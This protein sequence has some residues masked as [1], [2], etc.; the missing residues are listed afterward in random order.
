[1]TESRKKF[2]WRALPR[3]VK[4]Q[5]WVWLLLP[6]VILLTLL[7]NFFPETV[8]QVYAG[9]IR[10]AVMEPL[11][12]TVGKLPFSL[13]E[14]LILTA[15]IL[16]LVGLVYA[17]VQIVRTARR[18]EPVL[19]LTIDYLS[20]FTAVLLVGSFLFQLLYGLCYY[21]K[22]TTEAV[23][24]HRIH[25]TPQDMA[26][27]ISYLVD[28]LNMLREEMG[29]GENEK[30]VISMTAEEL[31]SAVRQAYKDLS[32]EHPIYAGD[33][34]D[35]K[36]VALSKPWTFTFVMGM[37]VPFTGEANYNTNIPSVELP[38][39]I[40]HE[41]AHQR[42]IAA[43]DEAN[44]AAYLASAYCKDL[45]VKYSGLFE[46]LSSLLSSL[47]RTD[48]ELYAAVISRADEGFL[49]ELQDVEDFWNSYYTS[50]A[51]LSNDINNAYLM[52]NGVTF[53]VAS[54][55]LSDQYVMDYYVNK[56]LSQY[57]AGREETTE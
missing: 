33:Y 8:E 56:H 19:A 26:W 52:S 48:A 39:T 6:L 15:G 23:Y 11:S 55:S 28:D 5:L 20:R 41:M 43:E 35:P 9:H 54:Y 57:I 7:A 22:N 25:Y 18:R 21:R 36:P 1:M 4:V 51:S 32:A 14:V 10:P 12:R 29:V 24:E 42:G 16:L 31:S 34:G 3:H 13:A 53:G 27:V 49:L 37:Y 50:L 45:R 30:V 46:T 38:H 17:I 40:L 47:K 44:F 2:R